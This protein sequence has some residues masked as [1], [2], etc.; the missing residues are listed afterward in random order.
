M[1]PN[2][3]PGWPYNSE[4][5]FTNRSSVIAAGR[6]RALLLL[7]LPYEEEE[8]IML[9]WESESPITKAVIWYNDYLDKVTQQITVASVTVIQ[10]CL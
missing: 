10:R 1:M 2:P 3:N 8:E 5:L 6:V 7:F 4:T 9:F